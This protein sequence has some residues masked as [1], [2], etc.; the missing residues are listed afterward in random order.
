MSAAPSDRLWQPLSRP[1]VR[2]PPPRGHEVVDDWLNGIVA[3]RGSGRA[4]RAR[5]A[6]IVAQAETLATLDE[7]SFDDR[8]REQAI[9]TR[10]DPAGA[11]SLRNG[12]AVAYEAVRRTTGISLHI[13]QVMGA[14][15]MARGAC[16]EMATGEGKT[17]TGILAG[18]HLGWAARGVHIITVN[19]YLAKRD[20]EITGPAYERLGLS[21]GVLLDDTPPDERREAYSRAVTFAADKQVI[22]DFLRDR[23]IAPVRPSL[24]CH[25]LDQILAGP[26]RDGADWSQRVVQ[27]GL[28]AAIVDE[29]DSVLIDEAT[30]PAIIASQID[31]DTDWG[32]AEH[33]RIADQI[34]SRL[35][36]DRDY[37]V[38]ERLSMVELTEDGR[39]SIAALA[40]GLPPFWSGPRRREELVKQA[41]NAR[42]LHVRDDDYVVRSNDEGAREI[43]IVDRSTGRILE[44]RQ[45][46]L[47]LHQAVEA[48]EGIDISALRT[49]SARTSYQ[50]F[51][52]RYAL[53]CGM[54][55][56]AWETR[57]E[58]YRDYSLRVVRIPTHRPV[59]RR[60]RTD[61]VS[62]NRD[63]KLECVVDAVIKHH[64]TGRP[65]L[66]GT[67]SVESSEQLGA[68]LQER[69]IAC[70]V[71]N[72]TREAEEAAIIAKAGERD[73]V[74]VATNMAGRGTDIC[75]TDETRALGGLVVIATERHEER[76][77]DRQ[78]F[79][80]AG[81]Q[82]DPG[83]AHAF[84]A[85]DDP[86][87]EQHGLST[88]RSL[89]R[90]APPGL[91][92]LVAGPLFRL[93]QFGSG[94][95]AA[96]TRR[97]VARREAQLE[98]SLHHA[99]R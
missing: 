61:H 41:L 54:T 13:E 60:E 64:A 90:H 25:L 69:G 29:A 80:R 98:L 48:K 45:W 70:Q 10:L 6:R 51:F 66:I 87:A 19:D 33:F 14:M 72:A 21:V 81:R 57:H 58:L 52:Q 74:T 37:K 15:E 30:T 35:I 77:V 28:Y 16:V 83:L 89:A 11:E 50:R 99:T 4:R 75:L 86:L 39:G 31:D 68:M 18:A 96:I 55:G 23:L 43:A 17:L 5:A 24:T 94:R 3:R 12:L 79:G 27:R 56:T 71:L 95:R 38:H 26:A 62:A 46:Q 97:E 85:L 53:L 93:A 34:A 92:G 40:N 91:R 78:L 82:G 32:G 76:R 73:T 65:V 1:F 49:T 67:R 8:V 7:K 22:F 20:A 42:S 44:G 63:E 36:A 88:L 84:V 59:V 2:R 47:G 9:A